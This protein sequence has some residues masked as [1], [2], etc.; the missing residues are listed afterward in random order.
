[1]TRFCA[2]DR[3]HPGRPLRGPPFH[4]VELMPWQ[5]GR[6]WR[7]P[8]RQEFLIWTDCQWLTSLSEG[9]PL[10]ANVFLTA[11][12]E[13]V[14]SIVDPKLAP[15]V[16]CCAFSAWRAVRFDVIWL[17]MTACWAWAFSCWSVSAATSVAC[18]A[19][20][21]WRAVRLDVIWLLI[22]ACWAWA[23]SAA[24]SFWSASVWRAARLDMIWLHVDGRLLGVGVPVLVGQRR[25]VGGLLGV[26]GLYPGNR[27]H[28]RTDRGPWD[29]GPQ[30]GNFLHDVHAINKD[31]AF[32]T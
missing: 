24:F 1:M 9:I 11:M 2:R 31:G 23:F 14:A 6:P 18:C 19:F 17:L 29:R 25:D 7:Q 22:T 10:V 4:P 3:G 26:G 28:E 20:S 27:C 8:L 12:A 13:I 5:C 16:A 30:I 15:S 21:A 32:R